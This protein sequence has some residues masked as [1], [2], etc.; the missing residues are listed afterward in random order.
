M[1]IL[2]V[3]ISGN[4]GSRFLDVLVRRG[5]SVRGLGRNPEKLSPTQL[6]SLEVFHTGKSWYDEPAIR[7]AVEGIDTVV[8]AYG[9]NPALLL[10][11][12][13]LL[14]SIMEEIGVKVSR[15]VRLA[16]NSTVSSIFSIYMFRPTANMFLRE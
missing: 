14:V 10:E 9:P 13:L 8:C 16:F 3:G 4:L 7:E 6:A 15:D 11:G 12:E 5:H 1:L 2:I